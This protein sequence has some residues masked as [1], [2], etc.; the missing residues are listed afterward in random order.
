MDHP[1]LVSGSRWAWERLLSV[2]PFDKLDVVL[3]APP[4]VF[5][6]GLGEEANR[7]AFQ[8]VHVLRT[9]GLAADM[10][11]DGGS[12]KSQMRKANRAASR[13]ALILGEN[14]IRSGKYQLKNM[15]EGEQQEI[16]A[17]N[18][19]EKLQQILKS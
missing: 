5:V 15:A 7:Q 12:M 16:D 19:T 13:Y 14:E 6:V 3:D 11:Y 2:I 1:R 9:S 18:L 17:A 8:I 10:D 4:D